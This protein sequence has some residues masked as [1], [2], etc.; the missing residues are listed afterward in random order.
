[1]IWFNYFI[2]ELENDFYYQK[3]GKVIVEKF[4]ESAILK[5]GMEFFSKENF[6]GAPVKP[7]SNRTIGM[8]FNN[9]PPVIIFTFIT[10]V[11]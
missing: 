5:F 4:R 9:T 8:K 10:F 7:K 3:F 1:M 2:S 11:K 6:F